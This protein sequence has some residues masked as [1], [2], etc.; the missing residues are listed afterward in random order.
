M[1]N[2]KVSVIIPVYG[3][4]A[5]LPDCI[6]SLRAQTLR[7]IEL[8]FIC[9]GSPDHSLAIL[10]KA[11]T[12]DSRIRV[13]AFEENQGVSAARNAGLDAARGDYIGFCDGDDW[14]EPEMVETLYR[15]AEDNRADISFCRVFKDRGDKHENVPLGFDDGT[16]FDREAIGRTLIPAMLSKP[17]DSDELPLS[18]YTPRN[19]FR[20]EVI[21][22]HRF[23]PDIRYAEDLLFIVTCMKDAGRAVAVDRA[24]YHYRFHTGSVTKHFSFHVPESYEKSND[25]LETLLADH[26]ECM[27]RMKIRRR[28]MAV[29]TVRNFC[30]PGTPYAFGERVR[31][32]K[33]YMNRPDV[34]A[35]FDDVK[36]GDFPAQLGMKLFLMQKKMAFTM[37]FLFTYVFDRV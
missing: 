21:G 10:R 13:I 27:R 7:D 19:L 6:A 16:G 15:A 34:A 29:N 11:E 8:I 1:I 37:C 4:E 31:R 33:A 22:S 17:T 26:P 20:R 14:A 3:A 32:A 23:R 12:L 30:Y 5:F 24:Y 25:A 36:P 9:D 2:P 35:L 28:K 18:G